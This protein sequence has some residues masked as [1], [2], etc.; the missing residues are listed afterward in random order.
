MRKSKTEMP[1]IIFDK[2]VPEKFQFQQEQAGP[3][4]EPDSPAQPGAFLFPCWKY[5][6]SICSWD[7]SAW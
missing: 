7:Y 2:R 4:S 5:C 1:L 6:S 3:L